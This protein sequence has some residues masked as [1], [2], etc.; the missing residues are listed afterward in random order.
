MVER[1]RKRAELCYESNHRNECREGLLRNTDP[2]LPTAR[3]RCLDVRLLFAY[4]IGMPDDE[5]QRGALLIDACLIAVIR[6]RGEPIQPS[7]KLKATISDSDR[8][9]VVEQKS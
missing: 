2:V 6:L 1:K 9:S 8:K 4:D 7:P 5:K 3:K